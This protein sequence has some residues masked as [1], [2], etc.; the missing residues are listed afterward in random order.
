[1][2]SELWSRMKC[3][4]ADETVDTDEVVTES[5]PYVTGASERKSLADPQECWG[6]LLDES[7]KGNAG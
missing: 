6:L 7:D 3:Y 5:V 4:F 2:R 1:M